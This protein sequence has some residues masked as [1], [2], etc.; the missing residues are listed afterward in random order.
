MEVTEDPDIRGVS[1]RWWELNKVSKRMNR[2]SQEWSQRPPPFP[3][4][5]CKRE[6]RNSVAAEG[7][8]GLQ[9]GLFL[10]LTAFPVPQ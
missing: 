2:R 3:K 5:S 8:H 9:G 4:L 7:D 6:Q 10:L 1:G